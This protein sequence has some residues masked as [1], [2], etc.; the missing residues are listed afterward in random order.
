MR[1]ISQGLSDSEI[2][3]Q[4]GIKKD[5]IYAYMVRNGY[6]KPKKMDNPLCVK[7]RSPGSRYLEECKLISFS[8]EDILW[9]EV[10]RT[11]ISTIISCCQKE[12]MDETGKK[13]LSFLRGGGNFQLASVSHMCSAEELSSTIIGRISNLYLWI[14]SQIPHRGKIEGVFEF[15]PRNVLKAESPFKNISKEIGIYRSRN[16]RAEVGRKGR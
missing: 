7:G 11:A 14:I 12:K 2:A 1:L 6:I 16:R 4:S 10:M 3:Q 5:C 15:K 9:R 8:N 13:A